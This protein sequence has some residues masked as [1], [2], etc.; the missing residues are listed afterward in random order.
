VQ[1]EP[2]GVEVVTFTL[3]RAA[4]SYYST[5]K[6]DWIAESGQF[7]VLIGSSSRDIKLKGSFNLQP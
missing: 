6:R 2:G 4:M 5:E 3:D 1:L 7:D